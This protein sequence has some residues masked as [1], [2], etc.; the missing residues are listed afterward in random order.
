MLY[1][2]YIILYNIILLCKLHGN[3]TILCCNGLR[4]KKKI[5]TTLTLGRLI[6]TYLWYCRVVAQLA[7]T[8]YVEGR[9]KVAQQSCQKTYALA[10]HV[11]KLQVVHLFSIL[12]PY[13]LKG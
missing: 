7:I 13:L 8:F 3:S 11:E 1:Y 12:M 5:V 9:T 6:R 4:K 10:I 2:I